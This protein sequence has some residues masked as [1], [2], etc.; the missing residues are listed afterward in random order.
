[1]WAEHFNRGRAA[2]AWIPAI[3]QEASFLFYVLAALDFAWGAPQFL[4]EHDFNGL[5]FSA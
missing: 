3:M 1:M 2:N 4:R 5:F